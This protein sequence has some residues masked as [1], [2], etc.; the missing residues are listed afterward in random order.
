MRLAKAGP[1][2]GLGEGIE[3]ALSAMQLFDTPCWAALGSRLA[4]VWLP[5]D[6]R[7]VMLFADNGPAG[8]EAAHKAVKAF[9]GL[10]RRVTL[11]LPPEGF[12][13]WNDA[14]KALAAECQS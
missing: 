6:V 13:D 4:S 8:L 10:Q 12:D 11:R 7:H 2:L 1:V 14:L 9:T 3:T 5:E